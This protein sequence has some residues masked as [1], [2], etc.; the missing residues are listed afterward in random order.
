MFLEIKWVILF[1]RLMLR[2][3]LYS[4]SLFYLYLFTIFIND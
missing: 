2:N 4:L 1:L 3:E